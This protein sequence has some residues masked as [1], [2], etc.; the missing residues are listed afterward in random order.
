MPIPRL[1]IDN[2]ALLVID[3]QE[4]LL[5]TFVDA[6][7][8][9]NNCA[10]AL[11]MAQ[12]LDL[13]NLVT[14]QYPKGLGRTAEAICQVM[15]DQSQRVEKTRFSAVVDV[16]D[17]KLME[18]Q[19]TNLLICGVEAHV[20][21]LQ[22]VLD[23]QASGRQCFVLT[24]AIAS[25]QRDQMPHALTR[26]QA[27]GAILTGVV[28]AMYELMDDARHPSFRNCLSLVKELEF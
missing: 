8:I 6:E 5:P 21:V 7:R 24:D 2:T 12:E 10:V 13:P 11:R 22:T 26:M 20:C 3:V 14:E 25:G 17:E 15:P 1:S 16:V 19:R 27:A 28:G 23:L 18:W 9:V 4:R